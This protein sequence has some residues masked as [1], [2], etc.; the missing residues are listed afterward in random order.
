M[1]KYEL[2]FVVRPDIPEEEVDK[3]ASQMEAVATHSGGKVEKTEKMGRRRLAYR[4][5]GQQEGLYVFFLL[6]GSSDT[7]KELERRL[8]VTDAIIKFMTVRVDQEL[9]RI[10]KLKAF[11]AKQEARRPRPKPA[12]PTAPPATAEPAQQ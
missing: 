2:I 4:I 1:H 12:P 3:I 7:V 11:R 10:E 5:R 9:Q 6:E 8:K